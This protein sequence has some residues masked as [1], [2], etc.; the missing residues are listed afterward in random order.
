MAAELEVQAGKLR[1]YQ[2]FH[3]RMRRGLAVKVHI[4]KVLYKLCIIS[5]SRV[6]AHIFK[7]TSTMY[8]YGAR[9]S[10]R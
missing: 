10:W 6:E 1:G 8:M 4:P 2:D 9:I 5:D 7:S 3:H